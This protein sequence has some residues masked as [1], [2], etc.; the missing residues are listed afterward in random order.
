MKTPIALE[1]I[2]K[3]EADFTSAL[4]EYRARKKPN[5]DAACFFSQ[6]GIEKY[7]KAVWAEASLTPPRTHD[8]G[9]LLA[10]VVDRYPLWDVFREV[11]ERLTSYAVEFRYP[12]ECATC[13]M[14]KRATQN[15]MA[16]RKQL[17]ADL[18]LP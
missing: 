8:L 3:A 14:A 2:E 13:E 11:M 5:Y 12:G 17:R 10:Q 1:W 6:Q 7:L 16:V 18:G 9:L 15:A 4:R